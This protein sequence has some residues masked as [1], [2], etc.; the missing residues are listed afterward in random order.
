MAGM[1]NQKKWVAG[2]IWFVVAG[3]VLSLVGL[4]FVS[5]GN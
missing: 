1:H 5:L 4:A 3:M 2:V